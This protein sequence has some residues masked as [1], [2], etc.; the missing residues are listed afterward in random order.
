M[1]I[2]DGSRNY[3]QSSS[4]PL[5]QTIFKI[6]IL[7]FTTCMNSILQIEDTWHLQGII[8]LNDQINVIKLYKLLQRFITLSSTASKIKLEARSRVFPFVA[9]KMC[10]LVCPIYTQMEQ[11]VCVPTLQ[12]NS[13]KRILLRK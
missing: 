1:T 13:G 5:Q 10:T 12:Y 3:F 9:T 4:K 8:K 6:L 2:Y 7:V 11:Y